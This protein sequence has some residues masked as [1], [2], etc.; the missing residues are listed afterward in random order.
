MT[1][2]HDQ[3]GEARDSIGLNGPLKLG[4]VVSNGYTHPWR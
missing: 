4:H 1:E 2:L 3:H